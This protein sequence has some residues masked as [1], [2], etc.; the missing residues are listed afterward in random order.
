MRFGP[1]SSYSDQEL[2]TAGLLGIRVSTFIIST[3]DK[4]TKNINHF[5]IQCQRQGPKETFVYKEK[6]FDTLEALI[7]GF[8]KELY[9]KEPCPGSKYSHLDRLS[10]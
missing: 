1:N 10:F 3:R 9:L 5:E 4:K 7:Q 2:A 6:T 8:K